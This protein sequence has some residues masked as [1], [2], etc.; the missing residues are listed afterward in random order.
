MIP[1][2]GIK[3]E[4]KTMTTTQLAVTGMTCGMCVG[5]VTKAL[6]S[7]PGVQRA[8]VD[9]YS[10]L[11]TVEHDATVEALVAAV[12]EEGYEVPMATTSGA[13]EVEA[14]ADGSDDGRPA[15]ACCATAS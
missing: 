12:E 4:E 13:M 8:K 3:R 11:A 14:S 9:L 6:Q 2:W 5:H 15:C 1:P 7:V 10:G